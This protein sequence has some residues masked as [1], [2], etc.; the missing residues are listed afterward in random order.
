MKIIFIFLLAVV[1]LTTATAQFPG[2]RGAGG[3]MNMG[4]AYGKIL[5]TKTGKPLEAVSVQILQMKYDSISKSR[6]ETVIAGQ[7]TKSNGDFNIEGLPIGAPLTVKITAIGYTAVTQKLQFVIDMSAMKN[8]DMSAML[9]NIDKDLGNL[10]IEQNI[11]KSEDV[12]VVGTRST[13]LQLGIDRKVFNVEKNIVSAGGTGVDILRN[14]PSV[15]VDL[16][17]NVTLRNSSPQIFVDG[18]PTPM[19]LDQIPSD[20]I[21]SVELIT[22]PSAK[23]DASGGTSGI[24]N[25]VLKKNRKAGYNGSVR[26]NIDSRARVGGGGD[27]NLRQNKINVF[28]SVNYNQRKSISWGQSNRLNF[29]DNPQTSINQINRNE[30]VGAFKFIRTGLDYF[31]DNRNT[32]SIAANIM[33]GNF[34]P[35]EIIDIYQSSIGAIS[36][37]SKTYRD[38]SSDNIF[39]NN[40]GTLSYKHLFTKPSQ[41]ITADV[42]FNKSKNTNSSDFINSP[43]TNNV[44]EQTGQQIRANGGRENVT[45]QTDYTQPVGKNAKWEAG[46]RFNQN[47]VFSI[48]D[49]YIKFPNTADFI[50]L[51]EVGYNFKTVEKVYA[52]YTT[53][54]QKINK[55][56]LQLGLRWESSSY[57]GDLISRNQKF[58]NKFP[59]SFFPS[60]F[61]TQSLPGGQDIQVNYTRKINRP[62]FF[63]LLPFVDYADSLNVTRG[64]PG[65]IPEF[66]NSLELSYQLPYGKNA[67]FLL[68]TYYKKTDNLIARFQG[69]ETIGSRELIVNSYINAN[70]STVYGLELTNKN[71]LKTWWE[72]ATN[73]NFYGSKLNVPGLPLIEDKLSWFGKINSNMKFPK[74]FTLQISADYQSKSVLP[75]GGNGGGSTFGGGGGGGMFGGGGRGGGFGGGQSSSTQGYIKANWGIDLAFKHDFWKDKKASLSLNVNDIF[76]TKVNWI[77]TETALFNQDYWRRRD[78]QVFRLNFSYRFGKFDASLFKRKNMKG[79]REGMG[80]GMEGMQ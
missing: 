55:T 66:T 20:A 61:I 76:Q 24:I 51:P 1:T 5:D 63:Q 36:N 43:Y 2:S 7:L 28:A 11:I 58:S 30:S 3:S 44:D 27:I 53:Y 29:F 46:L 32:F 48:N 18:R 71:N 75:P 72:L 38:I 26:A 45:I 22:N 70:A 35:E 73:I 39:R 15:Q 52:A 19:T 6:K 16:D 59:N 77:V 14:V 4:R 41:E 10:K 42:T 74:N 25:I 37:A 67:T 49:N 62:N 69:K 78:P 54:G 23:F 12:T 65:L 80:G 31:I 17:G 47:K 56:N 33:G 57:D 79:E 9:N 50:Y 34:K 13:A 8:G 68:S 60:I 21:A 40:G 64:N